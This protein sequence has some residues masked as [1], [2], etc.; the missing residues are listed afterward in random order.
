MATAAEDCPQGDHLRLPVLRLRTRARARSAA[1][2]NVIT[3]VRKE[4]ASAGPD[5]CICLSDHTTS[6]ASRSALVLCA[7]CCPLLANAL[8][9]AAAREA[10]AESVQPSDG[11]ACPWS[12]LRVYDEA[13]DDH[14]SCNQFVDV[15]GQRGSGYWDDVIGECI[16]N[17]VDIVSVVN[18]TNGIRSSA[19]SRRRSRSAS[20][21]C[22]T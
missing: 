21:Q 1:A 15:A 7:T 10:C 17:P 8:R 4:L 20:L 19:T 11:H 13:D 2:L 16:Q 5:A 22:M 9:V 12:Q 6:L 3:S 14:R 18:E